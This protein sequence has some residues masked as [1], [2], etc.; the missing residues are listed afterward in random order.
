MRI[1]MS[2]I[3]FGNLIVKGKL[4]YFLLPM[5]GNQARPIVV[6]SEDDGCFV[7]WEE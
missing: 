2:T 3:I 4:P 1:N 5:T 6:Q 7:L